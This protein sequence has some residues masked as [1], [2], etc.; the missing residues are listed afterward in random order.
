MKTVGRIMTRPLSGQSR[1]RMSSE[2]VTVTA[3]FLSSHFSFKSRVIVSFKL[4]N[5]KHSS[6]ILYTFHPSV[7][8]S[9]NMCQAQKNVIN[10][11]TLFHSSMLSLVGQATGPFYRGASSTFQKSHWSEYRFYPLWR[12]PALLPLAPHDSPQYSALTQVCSA[13][14][15]TFT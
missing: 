5:W 14:T 3:R 7:T 12:H 10:G 4:F 1:Q 2:C 15:L 6:L 11:E 9:T 8:M 13:F